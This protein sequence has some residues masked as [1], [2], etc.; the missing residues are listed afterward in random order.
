MSKN[1]AVCSQ[2]FSFAREQSVHDGGM[3]SLYLTLFGSENWEAAPSLFLCL[4]AKGKVIHGRLH[5]AFHGMID[6]E[7]IQ[8]YTHWTMERI[9]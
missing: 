2:K 3:L 1:E 4:L 8:S 6:Y 7:M 9:L 5:I